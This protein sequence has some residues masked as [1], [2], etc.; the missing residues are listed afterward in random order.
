MSTVWIPVAINRPLITGLIAS[1]ESEDADR[2]PNPVARPLGGV[3]FGNLGDRIGRKRVLVI[4]MMGMG[5]FS[6]VIGLLPTYQSIGL[7]APILLVVLRLLQV[8][9]VAEQQDRLP[10]HPREDGLPRKSFHISPDLKA[11]AISRSFNPLSRRRPPGS[12]SRRRIRFSPRS[13]LA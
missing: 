1:A 12:T 8:G 4:T 10:A 5:V 2:R 6:T 7:W 3:I 11:R 13:V 9:L